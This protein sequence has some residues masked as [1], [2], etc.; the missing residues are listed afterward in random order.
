MLQKAGTMTTESS[1]SMS[2][3]SF[4]A[5]G[6]RVDHNKTP[7]LLERGLFLFHDKGDWVEWLNLFGFGFFVFLN[8][9]RINVFLVDPDLIDVFIEPSV[10]RDIISVFAIV[11]SPGVLN[12]PFV[13]KTFVLWQLSRAC[14]K[15]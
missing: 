9:L 2:S 3:I 12:L 11:L 4:L 1:L 5:S 10:V 15:R 6:K 8:D 7:F 13:W 14:F